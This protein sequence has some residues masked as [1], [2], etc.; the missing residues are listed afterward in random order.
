MSRTHAC[1]SQLKPVLSQLLSSTDV[2][3]EATPKKTALQESGN[4]FGDDS[5]RGLRG[6]N[7]V[8]V[9]NEAAGLRGEGS[10]VKGKNRSPQRVPKF[11]LRVPEQAALLRDLLSLFTH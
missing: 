10:R 2:D 5:Q 7:Q 8:D 1:G 4:L 3:R 11:C 9:Q 6:R